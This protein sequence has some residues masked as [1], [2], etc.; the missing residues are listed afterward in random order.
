MD[1][2]QW[3][4]DK[5]KKLEHENKGRSHSQNVAIAFSMFENM[6]QDGGYQLPEYQNGTNTGNAFTN[7]LGSL[8]SNSWG[9]G[10]QNQALTDNAPF[11]SQN[12]GVPVANPFNSATQ[13]FYPTQGNTFPNSVSYGQAPNPSY[14][15]DV[16]S[17]NMYPTTNTPPTVN[18]PQAKVAIQ[19]K[20]PTVNP[21]PAATQK[22]EITP[23]TSFL[24]PTGITYGTPEEQLQ[25]S[26]QNVSADISKTTQQGQQTNSIQPNEKIQFANPYGGFDIPEA[27]SFLGQSIENK[28][29][30]GITG[31]GL[32]LATGLARNFFGGMGLQRRENQVMNDYY[33]K[34]RNDLTRPDILQK[35][36]TIDTN[37]YNYEKTGNRNITPS[38]AQ[39]IN[40][41]TGIQFT[42]E[43]A[44]SYFSTDVVPEV[45]TPP[46]DYSK[47]PVRDITSDGQFTNR[48]VWRTQ[49]PEWFVGKQTPVESKDYTTVPYKQWKEYQNSPEYMEYIKPIQNNSIADNQMYQFGGNYNS[50]SNYVVDSYIKPGS[51]AWNIKNGLKAIDEENEEVYNI[52]PEIPIT[53][54]DTPEAWKLIDSFQKKDKLLPSVSKFG[55][56]EET[57]PP[58]FPQHKEEWDTI[59]HY[60]DGGV[61]QQ[62]QMQQIEQQIVEALQKGI[63]PQQIVQNL[64]QQGIPQE[65]VVQ[66]VQ[67]IM[68][69]MNPQQGEQQPQQEQQFMQ[70]GG[71][72]SLAKGLTGEYM[73]GMDKQNP[74]QQPNAEIEKNEFVQHPTGE[75]QK[76]VGDTHEDGG[77][78]VHLADNTR[79]LSDHLKPKIDFVR[80]IKKDYGIDVKSSDTYSKI[81]DKYSKKIGLSKV[82]DEQEDLITKMEKTITTSKD[83]EALGLNTQYLSEKLKILEDK[84]APLEE[85][86][87]KIF[88]KLF[89]EQEDSKPKEETSTYQNGGEHFNSA[90]SQLASKYN[91]PKEE[92]SNMFKEGGTQLPQYQDGRLIDRFK[93]L[94]NRGY[95]GPNNIG[96][97]QAWMNQNYPNEVVDYFT[98][99]GQPMTAKHVDI[100]K[101]KY[102]DVFKEAGVPSNKDS[103]KYTP[104]EKQKL[105]TAL[106]ENATNEFWREGFNDKKWDWRFPMIPVDAGVK[107][108]GMQGQQPTTP[109]LPNFYQA[110]EAM[111]QATIDAK[112][113]TEDEKAKRNM[114]A[115][116][117][118][119]QSP[120]LP[121]SLQAHLKVNRR[122]DR[123]NPALV[124]PEQALQELN[125]QTVATKERL[126]TG[127]GAE[128]IAGELGLSANTQDNINKIVTDTEKLNSQII[129]N[130]DAR[131]ATIQASEEN[132]AA[133]DALSYEQRQLMA[134]ANTD[135][136]I[137]NYYNT[138]RENNVRNFNKVNDLNLLNQLYPDYQYTGTGIEKT[139]PNIQF[140]TGQYTPPVTP[141][142]ATKKKKQNGGRFKK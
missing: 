47:L 28:D 7:F 97:M 33:E 109:G 51:T 48:K 100:I 106:G 93:E 20:Q 27:A 66:M 21:T 53:Y 3:I 140:N 86:R 132:A 84:K 5:I 78:D 60:Q 124:S 35:G 112:N 50:S 104:E 15:M 26:I 74:I 1:K 116:F 14:G 122:F 68:Q 141:V 6:K 87:K 81:L 63:P 30:L 65:Q 23:V 107:A 29:A 99:N 95:T 70:N 55:K 19:A 134:K 4:S 135:R 24:Q 139:S 41:S 44:Q 69:Q 92:I 102:R 17:V 57:L 31:S 130:T 46:I 39:Q 98:K 32:K 126:N 58:V 133:S 25:A 128:R 136:D 11:N 105:K 67:Q 103:A 138:L 62:N 96:E 125:R 76:A 129:S 119:D 90:I 40:S 123:L 22:G 113:L 8:G 121:D 34:Q 16:S 117:L 54:N 37:T 2:N 83:E 101:D 36:G 111:G 88:D 80:K 61:Q 13:G 75:I 45:I 59:P 77:M 73:T 71:Q 114:H 18:H 131:N 64:V 52:K 9:E 120:M 127:A 115:L 94:K 42:P 12:Y 10:S 85:E 142:P 108:T 72:M 91:I 137:N 49:K 89:R 110:P 38:Q 43:F 118:P 82:V 56:S 79:I